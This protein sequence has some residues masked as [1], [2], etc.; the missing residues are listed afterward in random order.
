MTQIGFLVNL[1]RWPFFNQYDI[2][3]DR[4]KQ[5]KRLND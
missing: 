3:Y 4:E 1:D 2:L 5:L